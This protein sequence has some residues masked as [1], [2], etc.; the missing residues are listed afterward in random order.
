MLRPKT[1]LLKILPIIFI[2]FLGGF[3]RFY[4]LNWGENFFFHPDEYH[5]VAAVERLSFPTNINPELFSYGSLTIYLIYF[6][7]LFLSLFNPTFENLNP[8]LLGRFFSALFSTF[9]IINIYLISKRLFKNEKI[10]LISAFLAS[11]I[12]GS[13]QQAHFA[14][15]ESTLSFFLT[16]SV[17]LWI[18]WIEERNMRTIFLSAISLGFASATKITG[19]LVLP[20]LFILP[21]IPVKNFIKNFLK[22]LRIY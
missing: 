2:I 22:N 13:I 21:F 4:K 7:R 9:T 15:P 8:F 10:I 14:T 20:V 5:I 17:Y 18:R 16:P 6:S 1:G 12:P 11:L 19:V 3:F